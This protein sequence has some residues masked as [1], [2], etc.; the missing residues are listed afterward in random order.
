MSACVP[1]PVLPSR[2]LAWCSHAAPLSSTKVR[3][4]DKNW[5]SATLDPG[6]YVL[7]QCAVVFVRVASCRACNG[8]FGSTA[9]S[10]SSLGVLGH[11][12]S[13]RF[14][15]HRVLRLRKRRLSCSHAAFPEWGHWCCVLVELCPLGPVLCWRAVHSPTTSAVQGVH[16]QTRRT[17]AQLLNVP[18][19]SWLLPGAAC[20]GTQS[21]PS[22][23]LVWPQG[24]AG[25]PTGGRPKRSTGESTVARHCC[26]LL[27]TRG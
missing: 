18:G 23:V 15:C 12:L 9:V 4:C 7:C 17:V 14:F 26:Q 2:V 6:L 1:V 3:W 20:K 22:C 10:S 25:R 24:C 16:R 11:P 13:R 27:D 5:P 19:L 21:N 8:M